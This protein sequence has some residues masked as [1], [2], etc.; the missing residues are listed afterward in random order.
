MVAEYQTHVFLNGSVKAPIKSGEIVG[1]IRVYRDGV[2][3]DA[4][5]LITADSVEK[6]SYGDSLRDV[7]NHWNCNGK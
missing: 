4:I 7:A 3:C 1:E 2:E 5:P 6:A